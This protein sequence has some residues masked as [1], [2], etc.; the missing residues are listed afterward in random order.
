[1]KVCGT[2]KTSEENV[3]CWSE[4]GYGGGGAE[5]AVNPLIPTTYVK[6]ISNTN[7]KIIE[8]GWRTDLDVAD[9]HDRMV[10]AS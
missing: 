5:I 1:M 3:T 2:G 4:R 9:I 6:K 8:K 10:T 7:L